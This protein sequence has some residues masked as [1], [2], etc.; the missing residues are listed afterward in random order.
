MNTTWVSRIQSLFLSPDMLLLIYI[1]WRKLI[2]TL[3]M[4]IFF[5]WKVEN[6]PKLFLL[7]HAIIGFTSSF[8]FGVYRYMVNSLK[9]GELLRRY[10]PLLRFL[11]IFW[12]IN[13]A[14]C[15]S[16]SFGR[17]WGRSY[18]FYNDHF[19]IFRKRFTSHIL[20]FIVRH[21]HVSDVKFCKQFV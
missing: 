20:R 7:C 8:R 17:V 3:V 19:T 12:Y 15:L 18:M 14:F 16:I 2:K 9:I 1:W 10:F 13:K 21:Y 6:Y 11:K 5:S 4:Q